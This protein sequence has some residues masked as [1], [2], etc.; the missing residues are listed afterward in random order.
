MLRRVGD[1][2]STAVLVGG[3]ALNFW[4]EPYRDRVSALS[5]EG[6]FTTKD[7]DFCGN[8]QAVTAFA[9]RLNGRA[10]LLNERILEF[11][12]AD[13]HGRTVLGML[14]P[15]RGDRD[16]PRRTDRRAGPRALPPS[17]SA[18]NPPGGL[19]QAPVPEVPSGLLVS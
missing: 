16:I 6:P 15:P 17:P 12:T 10:E 2:A 1:V 13:R 19:I 11:C 5:R 14:V 9:E 8:R 18:A 7:I 4:A 3:Q